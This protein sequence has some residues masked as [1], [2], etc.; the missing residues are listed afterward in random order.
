MNKPHTPMAHKK[1]RTYNDI[2]KDP[3]VDSV[4]DERGYGDGVWVYLKQ[5]YINICLDSTFIHE[6]TI[7]ECC[8]QLNEEVIPGT[9]KS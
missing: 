4:S 6:H 1:A 8:Q 3:R 2:L 9:P 5:G 7:A